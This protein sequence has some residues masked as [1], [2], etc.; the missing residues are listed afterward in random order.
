[1]VDALIFAPRAWR[2]TSHSS[3]DVLDHA[4][5][6]QHDFRSGKSG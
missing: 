3:S 5:R 2:R 4:R 6:D 1:M